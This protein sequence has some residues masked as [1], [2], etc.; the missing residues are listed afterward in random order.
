MVPS[1]APEVC[2]VL[3]PQLEFSFAASP[4]TFHAFSRF[5]SKQR[6]NMVSFRAHEKCLGFCVLLRIAGDST[7]GF[8]FTHF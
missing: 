7:F 5:S 2:K 3:S 1:P 8:L 4:T 6:N